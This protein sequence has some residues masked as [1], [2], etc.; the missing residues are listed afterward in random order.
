MS[1]ALTEELMKCRKAPSGNGERLAAFVLPRRNAG[2][3]GG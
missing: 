2:H 3:G 1:W